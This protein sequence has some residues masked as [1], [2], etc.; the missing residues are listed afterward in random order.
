VTHAPAPPLRRARGQGLLFVALLAVTLGG[1]YALFRRKPESPPRPAVG[2]I[3]LDEAV[4]VPKVGVAR[5]LRIAE[6]RTLEVA[7]A[8][9]AGTT[10]RASFGPA[11][12]SER[13]PVD[14]PDPERTTTW[15]AKPGDPPRT[16]LT[17]IP[18]LYVLR[19]APEG[20]AP[21]GLVG[22]RVRA[23]PAK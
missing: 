6:P 22:L 20:D 23:D 3:V 14:E 16:L 9:A 4:D 2:A 10:V 1:G 19:L 12:A 13:S 18:G 8:P 5:R 21:A 11:Q 15:S 17:L 7:L